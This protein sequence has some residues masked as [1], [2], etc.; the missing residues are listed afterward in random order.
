LQTVAHPDSASLLD[1]LSSEHTEL[2]S[3][4]LSLLKCIHVDSVTGDLVLTKGLS[5]ITLRQNGEIRIQGRSVVQVADEN[6]TLNS[7]YIELN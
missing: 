3:R 7:A 6:I 5:C 2:A 4:L 1:L